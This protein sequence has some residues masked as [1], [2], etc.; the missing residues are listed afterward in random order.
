MIGRGDAADTPY[1]LASMRY[2]N[3]DLYNG[4][5]G[6]ARLFLHPSFIPECYSSH[7]CMPLVLCRLA[8]EDFLARSPHQ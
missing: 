3:V 8:P 1:A 2:L 5:T 7:I 6:I 4:Y